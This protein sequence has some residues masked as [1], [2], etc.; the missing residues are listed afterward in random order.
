[1][2]NENNDVELRKFRDANKEVG[3][4]NLKLRSLC[5]AA[6]LRC[7]HAAIEYAPRADYQR[8]AI[9]V[10]QQDAIFMNITE[11]CSTTG[12]FQCNIGLKYLQ[13]FKYII[14]MPFNS[15]YESKEN[16]KKYQV[17]AVVI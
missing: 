13:V 12:W 4:K 17:F 10:L 5:V 2:S 9:A 11:L 8:S 15:G 3:I 6:F 14:K 16:L 7:L 1:L